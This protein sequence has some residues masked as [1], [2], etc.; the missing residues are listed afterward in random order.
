MCRQ[1]TEEVVAWKELSVH[2]ILSR[3]M[4]LL[5]EFAFATKDLWM[6]KSQLDDSPSSLSSSSSPGD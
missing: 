2:N 6:E 5:C 1:V 4:T 3:V